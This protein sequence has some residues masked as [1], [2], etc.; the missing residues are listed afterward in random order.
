MFIVCK[1]ERCAFFPRNA[2]STHLAPERGAGLGEYPN[3]HGQSCPAVPHA[4]G[5]APLA[6]C[7]CSHTVVESSVSVGWRPGSSRV[8][9][10]RSA[11]HCPQPLRVS[12]LLPPRTP[13]PPLLI[14]GR[15]GA[16]SERRRSR[17]HESMGTCSPVSRY[18]FLKSLGRRGS[19]GRQKNM[20]KVARCNYG[21]LLA[22]S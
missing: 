13:H 20:S 10:G 21:P 18:G 15:T 4:C 8:S 22:Q 3:T 16:G 12:P 2:P 9:L 7:A 11:F 5:M 1:E 19:P 14:T 17:Q 6:V